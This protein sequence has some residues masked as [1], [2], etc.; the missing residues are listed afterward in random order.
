MIIKAL[1]VNFSLQTRV[2]NDDD[3]AYLFDECDG[4]E[5]SEFKI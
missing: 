1:V 5:R 4:E 2:R 3:L